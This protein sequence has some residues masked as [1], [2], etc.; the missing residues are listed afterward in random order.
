M[1]TKT[2][3]TRKYLIWGSAAVLAGILGYVIWKKRKG[4]AKDE[5]IKNGGTYDDAT[6]T[7]TLPPKVDPVNTPVVQT[8]T[9]TVYPATGL[10]KVDGDAFRAWVNTKYPAY[11]KTAKLDLIGPNDNT[12]IRKAFVEYGNEWKTTRGTVTNGVTILPT[13]A[14]AFN[15]AATYLG[16]P[17][18]FSSNG[19]GRMT[20]RKFMITPPDAFLFDTRFLGPWSFVVFEAD[21]DAPKPLF[22]IRDSK[23]GIVAEGNWSDNT[24]S[25]VV[26]KTY[27]PTLIKN[28]SKAATDSTQQTLSVILGTPVKFF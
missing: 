20:K 24:K 18:Y 1:A 21:S 8:I 23:D 15:K 9:E 27:I 14:E 3:G 10:S 4:K 12:T 2:T 17:F 19:V 5:C 7:C 16:T 28:G 11:A 6:K 26:T 22:Y 25:L 13:D